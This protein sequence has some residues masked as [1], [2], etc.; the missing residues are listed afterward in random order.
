M[1]SNTPRGL[2][3]R[4]RPTAAQIQN[5][6]VTARI[7]RNSDGTRHKEYRV[8]SRVYGSLEELQAALGGFP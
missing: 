4:D 3:T 5:E 7:I 6:R 8:G 1:S 2:R